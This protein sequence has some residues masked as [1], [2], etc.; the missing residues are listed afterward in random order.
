MGTKS[1][2]ANISLLECEKSL[3]ERKVGK[4]AERWEN[5]IK[6]DHIKIDFVDVG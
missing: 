1:G 2:W 6:S 4:F 3:G 5:E